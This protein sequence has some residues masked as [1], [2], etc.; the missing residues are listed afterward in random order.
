MPAEVIHH[1]ARRNM[2]SVRVRVMILAVLT[3][4]FMPWPRA[5]VAAEPTG[6]RKSAGVVFEDLRLAETYPN[7]GSPGDLQLLDDGQLLMTFDKDWGVYG[8][9]SEDLG[10]TWGPEFTLAERPR[11][12]AKHCYVHSSLIKAANGDLLLFYQYYVYGTRPVYKVNYYRRSVDGGKT[13]GDQLAVGNDGLFNDKLIR[14]ASGRLIAPVERE[15]EIGDSDHRG[16]V[17]YVYY[18]DD[19]GYSWRRSDNEVNV[20]PVEAQE[21]H[22]VELKDGRLMMLCRTYSGYVIRSYSKDGGVTWSKGEPVKDLILSKDSS[23]LSLKRIPSTGDL[24]L[25]RTTGGVSPYRTPLVSAVSTDEG[26]TWKHE[27]VIVHSPKETYG[28]PGVQFTPDM[29]LI[30]YSSRAGA[31][32]ARIGIDWFYEK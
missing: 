12:H 4:S 7:I 9:Y 16:Y 26:K 2:T 30:G 3:V 28:Y 11:P 5:I 18:S 31:H 13:W 20:L 25:L 10:K 29:A 27:R 17:S 24:L 14:L 8:R 1:A 23:A 19:H 6:G 22:V 32:L 15:A 21:P